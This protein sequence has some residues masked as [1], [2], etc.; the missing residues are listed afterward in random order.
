MASSGRSSTHPPSVADAQLAYI[1]AF[2]LY[3]SWLPGLAARGRAGRVPGT[4]WGLGF[5]GSIACLAFTMPLMGAPT[6]TSW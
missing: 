2:S 1:L 3:E 4:A 5:V 6:A